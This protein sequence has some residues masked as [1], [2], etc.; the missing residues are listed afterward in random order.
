M[1][2][3]RMLTLFTVLLAMLGT[4]TVCL[5]ADLTSGRLIYEGVWHKPTF[6]PSVD[7]AIGTLRNLGGRKA[8]CAWNGYT[9]G[10]DVNVDAYGLRVRGVMVATGSQY[11]ANNGG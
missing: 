11:V 1:R 8:L 5:A 3:F 6:L 4:A 10:L 9:D 7:A 2:R